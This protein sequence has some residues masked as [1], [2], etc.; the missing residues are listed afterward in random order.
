ML[1]KLCKS[2]IF[3]NMAVFSYFSYRL[4][5]LCSVQ[6]SCMSYFSKGYTNENNSSLSQ[7]FGQLN[8]IISYVRKS[9]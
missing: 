8:T 7:L 1:Y 3:V 5:E 9:V 2:L 4:A 6:L